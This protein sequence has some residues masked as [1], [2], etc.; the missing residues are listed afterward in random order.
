MVMEK[1]FRVNEQA[2]LVP[3]TRFYNEA[4]S[5]RSDLEEDYKRFRGGPQIFSFCRYPFLLEPDAKSR[6]LHIDAAWQQRA[7]FE[8][9][10]LAQALFAQEAVPYL[11]LSVR[12][13]NIIGDTLVQVRISCASV[14]VRILLTGFLADAEDE[15]FEKAAQSCICQ[16]ASSR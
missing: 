15:R 12:R 10:V 1:L 2:K 5:R 4:I 9:A 6:T 11:I 16:R 8:Q 14:C 13:D 3:Y 7:H